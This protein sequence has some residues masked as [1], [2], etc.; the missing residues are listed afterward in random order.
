MQREFNSR[1]V[2]LTPA[3][4]CLAVILLWL[5]GRVWWCKQGDWA[6]WISEAWN[7]SHT[8]QHLFD[9]YTFTHILHGVLEFWLIGLVLWKLPMAWRFVLAIFIESTWEVV[10]N[11]SYII[12]RYREATISLDYFG[13]SIANSIADIAA[14]AVGFWLAYKLRFWKSLILFVATE[15]ILLITVRDSLIVNLI[16]LIY[17]IDAIK[18]WQMG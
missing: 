13:D 14:C 4:A 1:T 18:T 5:N 8:S 15:A 17:P 3:I 12:N 11:S 9:P 6:I 16:M 7:S 2:Y 10:E